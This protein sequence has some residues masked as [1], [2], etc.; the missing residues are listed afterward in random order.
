[1]K[2]S[3]LNWL[4]VFI[5]IVGFVTLL[6]SCSEE[7][8]HTAPAIHDRDSVPVMVTYGVNTLVSDSG[9]IKYRIVTEQW[10]VNQVKKPSCWIFNKG[11][12]LTQFDLKKH[13]VGYI[14]CDSAIYYDQLQKWILRGRVNVL[15]PDGLEFHSDE[16]TW[17]ERNHEISSHSYSVLK[18][19]DKE[20]KGVWF[21]SDEQMTNYEIRQ[22][23]GWS[24]FDEPNLD[25]PGMGS[26]AP[27]APVDSARIDSLHGPVVNKKS[28][29][30]K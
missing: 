16:L 8:E 28:L 15:T 10:E 20:M 18:T 9:V 19:P 13:V 21:R 4:F 23:K 12:L 11:I 3:S 30:K 2:R 7:K 5:A 1:M 17:D 26:I 29:Q 14:Q 27:S 22:P 25:N 6:E 24:I